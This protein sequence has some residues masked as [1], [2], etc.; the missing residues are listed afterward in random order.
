[1][2]QGKVVIGMSEPS[3][4]NHS[5]SLEGCK[6]LISTRETEAGGREWMNIVIESVNFPTNWKYGGKG[7]GSRLHFEPALIRR[8]RDTRMIHFGKKMH[9][10]GLYVAQFRWDHC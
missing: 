4:R 9:C 8:D 3:G 2:E 1:M 5:N 6:N 7:M 10:D